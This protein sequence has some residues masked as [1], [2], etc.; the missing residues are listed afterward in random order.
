M[1]FQDLWQEHKKWIL[2]VV[3]GVIVFLVARG[4]VRS[5]YDG[6]DAER[7]VTTVVRSVRGQDLYSA[8]ERK[9]IDEEGR[10]LAALEARLR[11]AQEFVPAEDYVLAGKGDPDTWF[12]VVQRRVRSR[13]LSRAQASGVEFADRDL[14]WPAPV[15]REE[16]RTT[17]IGLAVLEQAAERLLD[18]GATVRSADPEALGLQSVDALAVDPKQQ[19]RTQRRGR[20][21]RT[22][23]STD[24]GER[25]EEFTVSF[26]FRCDYATLAR[27]FESCRGQD[28]VLTLLPELKIQQGNQIGDPLIVKGRLSGLSVKAASDA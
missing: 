21:R 28:P 16:I 3:A 12:D 22:G 15:G 9:R 14:K 2:G 18:A 1:D 8:D 7:R 19:G 17:L 10:A 27:F 4:V 24:I 13:L 11:S 25:V 26:T 23:D 20:V 5:V 6:D